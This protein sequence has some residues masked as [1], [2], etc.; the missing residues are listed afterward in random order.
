[1][2]TNKPKGYDYQCSKC[3][4]I[5]NL[6]TKYRGIECPNCHEGVMKMIPK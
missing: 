4:F 3:K 6:K 5:K 1:M 2:K